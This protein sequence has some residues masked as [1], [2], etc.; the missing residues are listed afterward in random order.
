ML[1]NR[2][3]HI[4]TD[5][6]PQKLITD[7]ATSA[8]IRYYKTELDISNVALIEATTIPKHTIERILTGK[9]SANIGELS[10]ISHAM[11]ITLKDLLD[12]IETRL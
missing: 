1:S 10:E 12:N 2:F 11:G 4:V 6:T 3:E 5:M 8:A 9:R 7:A